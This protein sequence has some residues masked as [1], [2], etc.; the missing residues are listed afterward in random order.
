MRSDQAE[1]QAGDPQGPGLAL[2]LR[3]VDASDRL[4]PPTADTKPLV[5]VVKVV[6]QVGLILILRDPI[7]TRSRSTAESA[8]GTLQRVPIDQVRQG[9][10]P[11]LR[12]PLRSFPY[13]QQFR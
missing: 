2:P 6:R 3:D 13:L 4:M 8:E 1:T 9:G 5:E 10:E 12:V 7:D 11:D